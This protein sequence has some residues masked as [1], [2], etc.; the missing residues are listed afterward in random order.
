MDKDFDRWNQ[1]KK[2]LNADVE[3]LYFREGEIW[4]VHLG[5]NIGYE[6]DGKKENFARPVIVLRKY[7]K[8]SFLALPLTTSPKLNPWKLPIGLVAG[9][10]A[11]AVL[12]QL[13]NIDSRRLY[14]KIAWIEP[15]QL[16]IIRAET[17][18]ANITGH[19]PRNN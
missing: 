6:I 12:S 8:Y 19:T 9:K 14:Q 3:P 5:V 7:N 17:L 13:R 16:Q 15:E 2:K 10:Q 4:W 1:A 18:K 11:F